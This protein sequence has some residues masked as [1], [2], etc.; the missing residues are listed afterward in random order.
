M[1]M[2]MATTTKNDVYLLHCCLFG[3]VGFDLQFEIRFPFKL[4]LKHV[5]GASKGRGIA[6]S[7]AITKMQA[8]TLD[9]SLSYDHQ[10][11]R[12]Q[13]QG[14]RRQSVGYP[15]K[16]RKFV[17]APNEQR[18][19]PNKCGGNEAALSQLHHRLEL[20]QQRFLC[21]ALRGVDVR[22]RD[23]DDDAGDDDDGGKKEGKGGQDEVGEDWCCI[24]R[25]AAEHNLEKNVS[26]HKTR[27]QGCEGG[28]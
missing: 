12:H 5:R 27:W 26:S 2:Q 7:H 8:V 1:R 15:G 13:Q 18:C 22:Q 25:N 17:W 16:R 21:T 23:G 24:E 3:S 19:R 9:A 14:E 28:K 10:L 6:L 20:E 11:L 4:H